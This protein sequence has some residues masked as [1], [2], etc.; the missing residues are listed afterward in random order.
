M[1]KKRKN[2]KKQTSKIWKC[3]KTKYKIVNKQNMKKAGTKYKKAK[4]QNMKNQRNKIWKCKEKNIK[5]RN[6]IWKN[7]GIN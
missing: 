6:K 4:K 5:T 1:K 7:K 3:K 2:I